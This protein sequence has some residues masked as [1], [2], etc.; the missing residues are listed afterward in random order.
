MRQSHHCLHL[1]IFAF[2]ILQFLSG[3]F[4]TYLETLFD[5]MGDFATQKGNRMSLES[6]LGFVA[7]TEIFSGHDSN[8][9]TTGTNDMYRNHR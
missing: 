2:Y 9:L 8:T 4:E 6:F 7:E 1:E 3:I 5:I